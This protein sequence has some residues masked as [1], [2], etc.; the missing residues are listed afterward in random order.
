MMATR[1]WFQSLL[2]WIKLANAMTLPPVPL[3]GDVS[4][5]VVMDQARQHR[6]RLLAGVGVDEVSILVVMDQARQ[7]RE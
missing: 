1:P 5:L 3:C 4:I 7:H 2:S 6:V